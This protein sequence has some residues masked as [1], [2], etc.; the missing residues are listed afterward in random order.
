M[1]DFVVD[2]RRVGRN[3][4][5]ASTTAVK[6][7]PR[8]RRG[9]LSAGVAVIALLAIAGFWWR[10]TGREGAVASPTI[11]SIAVLPLDNLSG[12]AGEEY[13]SDGMTSS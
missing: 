8:P 3:T 13:F 2:L 12:E 11:R 10:A 7:A 6:A 5:V 9:R 1:R 4:G